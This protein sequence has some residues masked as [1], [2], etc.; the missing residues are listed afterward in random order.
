MS[1]ANQS[2][3]AILYINTSHVT[4][5]IYHFHFY[6]FVVYTSLIMLGK[7]TMTLSNGFLIETH[8]TCYKIK[9]NFV[10]IKAVKRGEVVRFQVGDQIS[11]VNGVLQKQQFD[12]C[13]RC[14]R[15]EE[16]RTIANIFYLE[17]LNCFLYLLYNNLYFKWSIYL[18]KCLS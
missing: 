7:I 10:P 12:S 2:Q 14:W 15:K 8:E 6:K 5:Q 17:L 1:L 13:I 9:V 3:W 11:Y 4:T 16:K 18:Y